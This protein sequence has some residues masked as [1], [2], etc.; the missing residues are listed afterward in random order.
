MPPEVV[1]CTAIGFRTCGV[2]EDKFVAVASQARGLLS[3]LGNK[4]KES[5]YKAFVELEGEEF[6]EIKDELKHS[7]GV[8][9][10]ITHD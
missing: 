6:E 1:M 3:A 2:R 10:V 5:L 7:L 8:H 4:E 9:A